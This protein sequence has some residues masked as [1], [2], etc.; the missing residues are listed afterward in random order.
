MNTY[1]ELSRFV[2]TRGLSLCG[3]LLGGRGVLLLRA[4]QGGEL[5]IR[6]YEYAGVFEL[7]ALMAFGCGLIGSLLMEDMLRYFGR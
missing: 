4:G 5:A 1:H 3:L 2:L 6:L 7:A